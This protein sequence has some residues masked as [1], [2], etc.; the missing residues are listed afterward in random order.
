[1]VLQITFLCDTP[2]FLDILN[3]KSKGENN[4]RKRSWGMFFNS[5]LFRG[6]RAYWNSEMEIRTNDK[7]VNYSH[8]PTQ[9]KQ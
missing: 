8:G 2:K 7:Q 5:Q 6:R 9:T 3:G 4:K 1:M